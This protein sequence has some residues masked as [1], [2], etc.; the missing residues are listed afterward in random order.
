MHDH[1]LLSGRPGDAGD[2]AVLMVRGKLKALFGDTFTYPATA[3][4]TDVPSNAFGFPFIQ[5]MAE[6]GITSG[7]STT[8]F[9]PDRTLT[10][11]EMAVFMARAFLN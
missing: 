10:R 5:K 1:H 9:C 11:Q 8:Q 7:C 4:F 6:L 2:A 3:S